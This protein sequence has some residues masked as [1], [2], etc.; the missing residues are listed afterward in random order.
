M[1][2]WRDLTR[3]KQPHVVAVAYYHL[4]IA[5]ENRGR[6]DAARHA[7]ENAAYSN[8]DLEVAGR[9]AFNLGL[10]LES[11][12]ELPS[13]E[14]AYRR[15]VD[16]ATPE[17]ACR[18]GLYLGNVLLELGR[19]AAAEDAWRAA[20]TGPDPDA[21]ATAANNLGA[22]LSE[23][24]R[25]DEA[26]A[27]FGARTRSPSARQSAAARLNLGRLR[28]ARDDRKGARADWRAVCAAGFE[29]FASLAE[30]NLD[31]LDEDERA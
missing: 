12:Q 23:E 19:R 22:L 8:H 29:P 14:T 4:A 9:A 6:K 31:R 17:V 15:A 25:L 13:A 30:R 27:V 10:L 7:Y 21:A 24:D 18:A 11:T 3:S 20:M 16:I 5:L 1:L 28:V 2:I 26:F